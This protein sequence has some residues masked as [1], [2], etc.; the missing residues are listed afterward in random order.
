[1]KKPF[2]LTATVAILILASCSNDQEIGNQNTGNKKEINFRSII[3][4]GA[5][6]RATITNS[7]N[8]LGFTVTGWWDKVD[9]IENNIV[10]Y[11]TNNGEYLF[12]AVDITRREANM[13][14]WDYDPK[15]YWPSTGYGV[16]FFAYSPA[17]SKNV[18]TGLYEYKGDPIEYTIPDPGREEAQEDFLLAQTGVLLE[19][20]VNLK[21]V[22]ALSRVTFSAKKNPAISGI[23]YLIKSVELV[24]I[25]K[26]GKIDL[27]DIPAGGVFDYTDGPLVHWNTNDDSAD[28]SIV[29]LGESPVYVRDDAYH[30]ILGPTNALMVMP[31]VT[32]T[33]N[34]DPNAP[35]GFLI[36]V[37]Y[38]AFIEVDDPGTYYAGSPTEYET[39]Y[40][41]APENKPGTPFTFE[42]GRQYNF[43][44]KFG[45]E[46]GGK[47]T[48]DVQTGEW[49][50]APQIDLPQITDYWNNGEGVISETLAALAKSDYENG[51]T[52]GDI[53]KHTELTIT[54]ASGPD[55]FKGLEYFTN[56]TTINFNG[57]F[58]DLEVSLKGTNVT[59]IN[60]QGSGGTIS[61]LDISGITQQLTVAA[62]G[63]GGEN[64]TWTI[65]TLKV[66]DNFQEAAENDHK[67]DF[68]SNNS[69]TPGKISVAAI[70]GKNNQV[71]S[72]AVS[73][74]AQYYY[75]K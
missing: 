25:K 26:T 35:A 67:V 29:D 54:N 66:W 5:P 9:D 64:P 65:S 61:V 34:P 56:L 17:S 43:A 42:I 73:P 68:R 30:S 4:K 1:M 21:F 71:S 49:T 50:N 40:F 19:N 53:L 38:K 70:D 72:I 8:I 37:E 60:L 16:Y 75:C 13:D 20:P 36:K 2:L 47:I 51:V 12:N 74:S 23:T 58:T 31:Q 3:D 55:A 22:H 6:S 48:F 62:A 63:L 7:D 11:P 18:S 27:K 32:E 39:V 24:N 52:L 44:L 28:K 15:L 45:S 57:S 69:G 33:G 14:M 59:R 10:Q 41:T 46:A